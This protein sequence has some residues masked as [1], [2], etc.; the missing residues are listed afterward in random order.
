MP[1]YVDLTKKKIPTSTIERAEKWKE[2]E[3]LESNRGGHV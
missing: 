1:S 2:G 3:Q